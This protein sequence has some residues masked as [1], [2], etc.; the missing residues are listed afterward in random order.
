MKV[1]LKGDKKASRKLNSDFVYFPISLC[2]SLPLFFHPSLAFI[3]TK[4][5]SKQ[6]SKWHMIKP[7]K[8]DKFCYVNMF[9]QKIWIWTFFFLCAL[10]AMCADCH[11]VNDSDGQLTMT[12]DTLAAW[13][14]G[15]FIKIIYTTTHL[16]E[17]SR[18]PFVHSRFH[19][20]HRRAGKSI[21]VLEL[22]TASSAQ[23]DPSLFLGFLFYFLYL[24]L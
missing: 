4:S 14:V 17:S 21:K 20:H 2:H 16:A 9:C 12:D 13:H 19:R 7:R 23:M 18:Q 11:Q 6:A 3:R 5:E 22:S 24:L 1:G 8:M 15:Y 10:C